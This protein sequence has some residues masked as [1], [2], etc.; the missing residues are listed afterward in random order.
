MIAA[1]RPAALRT[2]LGRVGATV[3]LLAAG[4]AVGLAPGLPAGA[5]ADDVPPSLPVFSPQPSGWQPDYSVFPYNLWR[6]RVTPEMVTALRDA[7][8]WFNAQY[9]ALSS[10]AFGFQGALRENFDSWDAVGGAGA[11]LKANIDQSTAFLDPRVH[12][13][14]ITN[15][16]DQS[17]YS[18]LYNGDSFYHLWFQLT[19]VSDKLARQLPSGVINANTATMRV[20][21]DVIRN[22][23]V[24]DGA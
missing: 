17:R 15:Y 16:P 23:G 12:T 3:G 8:Q 10:Q 2:A 21:G 4:L 11:V 14:Y 19:G 6:S 1:L 13:L 5:R 7:C 24:C 20:Y 18:P 22:S 9:D